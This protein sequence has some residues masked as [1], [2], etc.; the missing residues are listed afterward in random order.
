MKFAVAAILATRMAQAIWTPDI[1]DDVSDA[2]LTFE[3]M[4]LKYGFQ[5]EEHE[6]V[7]NDGYH[8]TLLRIPGQIGD[9]SSGKPP[10]LLNHGVCSSA[11]T[12]IMNYDDV[13]PGFASARAG[14]DVWL[15]NNRGNTYSKGH[16][17]LSWD[18]D[19][20]WQFDFQ[21]MGTGDQK[22]NISYILE[23]TG[24]DSLPYVGHS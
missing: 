7:T 8:L 17:T 14:Y 12:W 5:Y 23:Q 22:A 4:C 10:V 2:Y 3:E 19:A 1:T 11:D 20:Y 21:E 6:V 9:F 24:Y 16:D 18:D 15:G 13:S